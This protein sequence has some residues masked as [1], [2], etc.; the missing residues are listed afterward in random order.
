[1]ESPLVLGA[2]V[3]GSC[4][5]HIT[6][7]WN[8]A[9]SG[10]E[11]GKAKLEKDATMNDCLRTVAGQ[12]GYCVWT[13]SI[14]A[15]STT[16]TALRGQG[17]AQ[18]QRDFIIKLQHRCNTTRRCQSVTVGFGMF[19]TGSRFGMPGFHFGVQRI[20]ERRR[21]REAVEMFVE[22]EKPNM[23]SHRRSKRRR[24]RHRP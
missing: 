2:S 14:E 22:K 4:E 8:F 13:D 3:D 15:T 18:E 16:G 24:R 6:V 12:H 5:S 19:M 11:A 23:R 1:M 20:L 7:E 21:N 17:L 10:N 9:F